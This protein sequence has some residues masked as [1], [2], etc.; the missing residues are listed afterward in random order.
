MK[1]RVAVIIAAAGRGERLGSEIPKQ[2]LEVAGKPVL[3]HTL[4]I[5][6]NHPEISEIVVAV[7]EGWEERVEELCRKF[8]IHKVFRVVTGGASRQESVFKAFEALSPENKIV[9]VHD[10]ARPLVPFRVISEVIQAIERFGAAICAVPI[11]DT[12]KEVSED[13]KVIRTLPRERLYLAQTPQGSWWSWFAE[14]FSKALTSGGVYT[15][16]A[17]L[18]E[19]AGFTVQVVPG[20]FTN[21][22]ITYPED[23]ILMGELLKKSLDTNPKI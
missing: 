10:A 11:R 22:K 5:F 18:L 21:L 20:S 9:L 8:A 14:A 1:G 6:E 23:L 12:V 15:D 7:P 3:I 4:S 17:S 19:A 16:E 2:F 13:L